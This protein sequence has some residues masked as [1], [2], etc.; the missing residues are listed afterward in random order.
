[1][2]GIRITI[3]FFSEGKNDNNIIGNNDNNIV[4]SIFDISKSSKGNTN[5]VGGNNNNIKM[6]GKN[7]N[8]IVCFKGIMIT[9]LLGIMIIILFHLILIDVR[10]LKEIIIL[11]G[12]IITILT[13]II[14]SISFVLK[15]QY[16]KQYC[17]E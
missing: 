8:N 10:V 2:L 11:L 15:K 17:W 13:G 9:I 6:E 16:L 12:I 1:M 4:S 14:I 5:I 7:Y 3:L